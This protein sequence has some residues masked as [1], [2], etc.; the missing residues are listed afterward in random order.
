MVDESALLGDA[1][2]TDRDALIRAAMKTYRTNFNGNPKLPFGPT[3]PQPPKPDLAD[4]S[5]AWRTRTAAAAFLSLIILVT[6]GRFCFWWRRR[7]KWSLGI[8]DVLILLAAGVAAAYVGHILS[9]FTEGTC[10]GRHMWFCTYEDIE[11]LYMV[12][13]SSFILRRMARGTKSQAHLT[14]DFWAPP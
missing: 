13:V 4:E 6:I 5:N 7:K 10:L 12:R 8:D 2:L 9:A 11:R 3:R 14:G 1:P